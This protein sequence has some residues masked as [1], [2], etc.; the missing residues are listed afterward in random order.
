[1]RRITVLIAGVFGLALLAVLGLSL[2]GPDVREALVLFINGIQDPWIFFP[3]MAVLPVLG[4]PISVFLVPVGARYGLVPGLAIMAAVTPLHLL[5]IWL[6][7]RSFLRRPVEVFLKKKGHAIPEI[8]PGNI[9]P[10]CFLIMVVPGPPF[11]IKNYSAALAGIPFSPYFWIGWFVHCLIS[12]YWVAIGG[13]VNGLDWRL[14][15]LALALLA[16]GYLVARK[17]RS[18]S[19][20]MTG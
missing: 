11:F 2:L 9:T 20:R 13:A 10:A 17:I 7:A 4:C 16:T 5:I 14:L 19:G 3:L 12:A 6:M 15:V 18:R 1:M 8:S